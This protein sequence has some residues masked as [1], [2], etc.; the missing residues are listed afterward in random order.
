MNF[1]ALKEN[2]KEN[3]SKTISLRV[4]KFLTISTTY[5]HLIGAGMLIVVMLGIILS[6]INTFL[7][8]NIQYGPFLLTLSIITTFF[9]GTLA[10]FKW[11]FTPR[12]M[13]HLN[14]FAILLLPPLTMT[15]VEC[16]NGVF[17]GNWA[18]NTFVLNC[19]FYSLLFLAIY[20]LSGSHRLPFLLL[21]PILFALSLTNHYV[22]K[23]RGTPFVPMDFFSASTAANVTESYDFSFNYQIIISIILLFFIQVVAW[24]IKTPDKKLYKKIIS[25]LIAGVLSFGI[26]VSYYTSNF[27]VDAGLKPFFF[28][29][30]RA[31]QETGVALNFW[32]NTKY[33]TVNAP[34]NY[35]AKNI[36][37]IVVNVLDEPDS[38][39]SDSSVS[40]KTPNIIC[41]MNETLTDLSVLGDLKTNKD[42]IPYL[43]NLSENTVKGTL[44]VPVIGGGTSNT[45]YEFLTGASTAFLPSSSNVYTLYVKDKLNSLTSS[46][47]EQGYSATAFHPYFEN[48]WNRVSVYNNMGFERFDALESLFSNKITS[49]IKTG[50]TYKDLKSLVEAELPGEENILLRNVVS[51]SYNYKKVIEMYEQR[52]K[53]K[54]FYI[55]NVTMQNHGGYKIKYPDFKEEIHLIDEQGNPID[56]YPETN[57]FLSLIYESDKAF[58]ELINYF[59]KQEEPTII[60][61]FGDH[62]PSIE[63]EFIAELYGTDSGNSINLQQTQN[64]YATP[65][66]IW[67]NYDIEEK[68][69][70]KLSVNYLS[71][72][73]MNIAGLEMP[74]FN[75]YLL[76]LSETLPVI[77]TIGFIDNKGIYY[78]HGQ[79]TPYTELLEGYE[80]ICYNYL[81]DKKNKCDW[82]FELKTQ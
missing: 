32:L 5:R 80:N 62:Q 64:R 72:Y 28:N 20:T 38:E 81:F 29:Q 53:S 16:L 47:K 56:K 55:F 50:I 61:M 7:R 59:E 12:L 24:K 78:I 31:Y 48:S 49:A 82:L 51:D 26:L 44:Y 11:S 22:C 66:Y 43:R 8:G 75:Q 76:K 69:I 6:N 67:A 71:S 63:D 36:K 57:Q 68:Q 60:C 21:T 9:S 41:I 25:R 30:K 52:D 15:M 3:L 74:V 37:D 54:P 27:L 35:N 39:T 4:N 65:F 34:Q 2:I 13:K 19:I 14:R 1:S 79:E 18:I 33:L 73:L 45:E 42:Y 58:K 17:I 70:E 46:L 23:F 40:K 10:A 77:D